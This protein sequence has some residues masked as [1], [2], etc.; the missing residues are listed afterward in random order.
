MHDRLSIGPGI[1]SEKSRMPNGCR[2]FLR[3]AVSGKTPPDAMQPS[4]RSSS[5]RPMCR[6]S[7][8]N[9]IRNGVHRNA[10][11]QDCEIHST[12]QTS[13]CLVENPPYPPLMRIFKD[14]TVDQNLWFFH[15]ELRLRSYN[16]R[17]LAQDSDRIQRHL[18]R[19]ATRHS[20]RFT[21]MRPTQ[22][23]RFMRPRT[24]WPRV[25]FGGGTIFRTSLLTKRSATA[26]RIT[27]DGWII[28]SIDPDGI[29]AM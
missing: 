27:D 26:S 17:G 2:I 4:E 21:E 8:R 19:T 24:R 20:D 23:S 13:Q 15:S 18:G 10:I 1:A 22:K 3:Q 12:F 6:T 11:Y 28:W 9:A 25:R 16:K 5:L 7:D 29:S 14:N